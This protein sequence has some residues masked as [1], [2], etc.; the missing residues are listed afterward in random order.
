[1]RFCQATDGCCFTLSPTP[2]VT[3]SFATIAEIPIRVS[4]KVNDEVGEADRRGGPS[5]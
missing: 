2:S 1:M 4:D 3:L 5:G